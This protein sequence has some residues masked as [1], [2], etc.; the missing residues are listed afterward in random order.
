MAAT[1]HFHA[2]VLEAL[3]DQ[4]AGHLQR[5]GRHQ[6]LAL[7]GLIQQVHLRQLAVRMIGEQRLLAL[8]HHRALGWLVSCSTAR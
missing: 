2:K 4:A 5:L 1:T 8:L 6:L 3:F 7:L